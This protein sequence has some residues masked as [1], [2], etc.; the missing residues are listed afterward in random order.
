[1]IRFNRPGL[2]MLIVTMLS[3]WGLSQVLGD[4]GWVIALGVMIPADLLLRWRHAAAG[5]SKWF[6]WES[7]GYVL[8]I[9]VWLVSLLMVGLWILD[10]G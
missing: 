3:G 9:P 5:W 4:A 8:L 1:M 2:I 7:G 10:M 6:G